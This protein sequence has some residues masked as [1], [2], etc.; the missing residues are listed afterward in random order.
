M[1]T[2]KM[3]SHSRALL[4]GIGLAGVLAACSSPSANG[5]DGERFDYAD[6]QYEAT[7]TYQSP[8]GT[9]TLGVA[10]TLDGNVI[11]DVDITIHP[12]DEDEVEEFQGR[13]AGGIA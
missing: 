9:E 6:G 10:V 4:V 13:F 3:R 2:A 12:N 11:T 8:N 5:Q 7:G 1:D